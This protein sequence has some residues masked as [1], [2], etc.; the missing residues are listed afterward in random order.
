[1]NKHFIHAGDVEKNH[2]IY[3]IIRY[4]KFKLFSSLSQHILL[5]LEED[6]DQRLRILKA[7]PQVSNKHSNFV[8]TRLLYLP[9]FRSPEHEQTTFSKMQAKDAAH[10]RL[11][12]ATNYL[13]IDHNFS[14]TAVSLLQSS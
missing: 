12:F 11:V 3:V 1:M 6:K 10:Q 14:V 7:D 2:Y 13:T 5:E 8:I 9:G 4:F